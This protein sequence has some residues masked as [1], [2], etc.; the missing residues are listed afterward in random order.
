MCFSLCSLRWVGIWLCCWGVAGGVCVWYVFVW[1]SW[2][3]CLGV[4]E[5]VCVEFVFVFWVWF[6]CR[7]HRG[8]AVVLVSY[9]GCK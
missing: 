8:L 9:E 1:W 4:M 3:G 2:F 5:S 7:L 6:V